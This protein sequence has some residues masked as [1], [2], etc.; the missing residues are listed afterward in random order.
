MHL[1]TNLHL[2]RYVGGICAKESYKNSGFTSCMCLD[3]MHI[4]S[5]SCGSFDGQSVHANHV[6]AFLV[7]V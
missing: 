7:S 6:E 2:N 5:E 4:D 3:H 1:K